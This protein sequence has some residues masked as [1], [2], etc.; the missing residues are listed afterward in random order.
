MHTIKLCA[1]IKSDT[2]TLL[3]GAEGGQILTTQGKVLLIVTILD[4]SI[5]AT[6][7]T[8]GHSKEFNP[9]MLWIIDSLGVDLLHCVQDIFGPHRRPYM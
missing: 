6:G 9:A 7:I 3:R 8:L 1:T 4:S 5:T 2:L